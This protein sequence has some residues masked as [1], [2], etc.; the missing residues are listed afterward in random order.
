V[1]PI[2]LG[3]RWAEEGY[4]AAAAVDVEWFG[5]LPDN[6]VSLTLSHRQ[7]KK[8]VTT[9]NSRLAATE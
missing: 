2:S 9:S 5:G 1:Q 4:L 7:G 8:I 3:V 6:E